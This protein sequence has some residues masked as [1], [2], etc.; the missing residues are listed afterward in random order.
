MGKEKCRSSDFSPASCTSGFSR[1]QV[2]LEAM[3]LLAGLFAFTGALWIASRPLQDTA[4]LD[5][6]RLQSEAAFERVRFAV[7]LAGAS[8]PGF[9]MTDSFDLQE[10]AVLAWNRTGLS[11]RSAAL[12][13]SLAAVFDAGGS[14]VLVVGSHR[15][16]ALRQSGGIALDVS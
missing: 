5:A 11:W 13:R 16:G 4:L 1:G 2:T 7:G 12:N 15:F 9:S 6:R 8:A 3:V 10:P 14:M